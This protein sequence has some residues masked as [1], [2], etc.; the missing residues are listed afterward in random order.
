[1]SINHFIKTETTINQLLDDKII[2][3]SR[4]EK[5]GCWIN[6]KYDVIMYVGTNDKGCIDYLE[7]RGGINP[8]FFLY[9]L[10]KRY[11]SE[12][13]HQHSLEKIFNKKPRDYSIEE[14]DYADAYKWDTLSLL[15][16]GDETDFDFFYKH[17][18][19]EMDKF[20]TRI[21]KEKVDYYEIQPRIK[22]KKN[23]NPDENL[24]NDNTHFDRIENMDLPF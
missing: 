19:V 24:K 1:M 6:D 11:N 22:K 18:D 3:I 20:N 21:N 12:F 13:A 17:S 10:I 5:E 16:F 8:L 4:I 15:K 9:T 2:R 23:R 14:I 7:T